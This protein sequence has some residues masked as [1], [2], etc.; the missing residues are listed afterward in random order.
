V[1][2]V[3]TSRATRA[4]SNRNYD[5]DYD[6]DYDIRAGQKR[7]LE[8]TEIR[9]NSI[10]EKLFQCSSSN[11]F[12]KFLNDKLGCEQWEVNLQRPVAPPERRVAPLAP[13]GTFL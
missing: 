6:Y 4:T 3:Q 9:R 11:Q 10:D 1:R 2:S 5:Y 12:D 8:K 7:R 13:R